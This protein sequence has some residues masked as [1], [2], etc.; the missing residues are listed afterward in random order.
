MDPVYKL[1]QHAPTRIRRR[2]ADSWAQTEE[3]ARR[4][5]T[6]AY[7]I[8]YKN[9][10]ICVYGQARAIF[11]AAPRR[12]AIFVYKNLQKY[13]CVR[14]R[15]NFGGAGLP[16]AI[17]QPETARRQKKSG[18]LELFPCRASGPF[19][20][21]FYSLSDRVP[22][23]IP[24]MQ[25]ILARFRP[26]GS[27]ILTPSGRRPIPLPDGPTSTAPIQGRPIGSDS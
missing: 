25:P 4:V 6:A 18:I 9:L 3:P 24:A 23:D 16:H 20:A 27:P 26:I 2:T 13:I 14:A 5:R 17:R 15:V 7:S 11:P 8:A 10:Q 21:L 1:Q 22:T 19:P 12:H